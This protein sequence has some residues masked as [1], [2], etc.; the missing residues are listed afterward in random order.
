MDALISA[1]LVVS[2]ALALD[3]IL[4]EPPNRYHPL[5]WMGNLLDYLDDR[6]LRRNPVAMRLKGLLSYVLLLSLTLLICITFLT[7]SRHL[8]GDW[9][10]M[11]VTAVLFKLSF[12]V[13]S[14]RTHCQPIEAD[15]RRGD[16]HSARQKTQMIVSRDTS[17]LD[18]AHIASCC[19]ETVSENLVDSVYSPHFYFGLFGIFGAFMFRC[20]N[21]M[22]AMWGYRNEKYGDLGFFPA[23]LDDVLGYIT[24]RLSVFFIILGTL[25]QDGDV[26]GLLQSVRD[27]HSKTLSPNSAWP[28]SAVAGSLGY[29]MEKEGVYQMGKGP[30]PNAE[31]ITRTYHL[32]EISSILFAYLVTLP[33]YIFIGMDVQIMLEDALWG[34]FGMIL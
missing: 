15:L 2:I 28:M 10:W 9:A 31:D 18:E 19:V 7:L 21:L 23:H 32:I 12:A 30:L 26:K 3:F 8:L 27:G 4:G 25:V 11:L 29:S 22:D 33:L 6:I 1:T 14:F 34:L 16:L 17:R 20:A 5:R 24:A 13:Y